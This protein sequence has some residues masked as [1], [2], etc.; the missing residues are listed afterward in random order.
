MR[1]RPIEI[2]KPLSA[3]LKSDVDAE[4][5]SYKEYVP[6]RDAEHDWPFLNSLATSHAYRVRVIMEAWLNDYPAPHRDELFRRLG[7]AESVEAYLEL[8]AYTLLRRHG[9]GVEV[10]SPDASG[11]SRFPDFLASFPDGQK[12]IFEAIT[13]KGITNRKAANNSAWNQLYGQIDRVASDY[14]ISITPVSGGSP[15]K[16]LRV[17]AFLNRELQ[18][19]PAR[20][21]GIDWNTGIWV[22]STEPFQD[23]EK[24]IEFKFRP[25][26]EKMKGKPGAIRSLHGGSVGGGSA[27]RIRLA[28]D[29]KAA[30]YG[31]MKYPYVVMVNSVSLRDFFYRDIQ[32]RLRNGIEALFGDPSRRIGGALVGSNGRR[33]HPQVSGVVIGTVTFDLAGDR[34]TLYPNPFAQRNLSTIPWR[35]DRVVSTEQGY[36]VQEGEAIGKVLGIP[37]DWP[38]SL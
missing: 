32:A 20:T 24:M 10:R 17:I 35:L 14:I 1:T 30:A 27:G 13:A 19:L 21:D 9:A 7:S 34:L 22:P 8:V 5:F 6:T 37:G 23:C 15:P 3:Y 25:R 16:G 28:V 36:E 33:W 18:K 31:E 4:E 2:N 12:V 26:T 38:G 29:E 11:N